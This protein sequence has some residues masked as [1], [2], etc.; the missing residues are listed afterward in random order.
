MM[1]ALLLVALFA[2][3]AE[4]A[5]SSSVWCTP[6]T[7]ASPQCTLGAYDAAKW[8]AKAVFDDSSASES[9]LSLPHKRWRR[10]FAA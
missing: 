1:L 10:A 5:Q 3:S 9:N 7:D 8:H 2:T 4:A 6:S